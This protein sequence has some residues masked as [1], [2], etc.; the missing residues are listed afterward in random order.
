MF[1]VL[2]ES[3]DAKTEQLPTP[4]P[5]RS[6]PSSSPSE[7]QKRPLPEIPRKVGFDISSPA[8]VTTKDAR[9]GLPDPFRFEKGIGLAGPACGPARAQVGKPIR[10]PIA[11]TRPRGCVASARIHGSIG[12]FKGKARPLCQ[13]SPSPGGR[14]L[15]THRSR[16]LHVGNCADATR[17]SMRVK[18]GARSAATPRRRSPRRARPRVSHNVTAQPSA[19]QP[20]D[21]APD[22]GVG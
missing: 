2:M 12:H 17:C 6:V 14:G 22:R 7:I 21:S 13:P 10:P 18:T 19:W 5:L 15:G 8:F 16:A 11:D 4:S 9:E 3:G 1:A 20:V